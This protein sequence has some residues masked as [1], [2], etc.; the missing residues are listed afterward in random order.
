MK[1]AIL[2]VVFPF[3]VSLAEVVVRRLK[4]SYRSNHS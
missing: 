3:V 4:K 2:I 1:W